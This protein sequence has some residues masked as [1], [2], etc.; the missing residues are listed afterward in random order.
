[1]SDK[2]MQLPDQINEQAAEWFSLMQSADV[3]DKD[4][5]EFNDWLSEHVDHQQAYEQIELVWQTLGDVS[6]T[7]EGAALS[8]S[9]EPFSV[10]LK[11]FLSAPVAAIKSLVAAPKYAMGFAVVCV[12]VGLLLM[13]RPNEPITTYYSTQAGEIK[14]II[15]ADSSE[16]TL[17]A[18]SQISSRISDS[19]RS[20]DLISGEAFFD[21]ASDRQK[22]FFV[23]VNNV[24]VEV[25]GTQFNVQKIRDVVSVAV[26]EGV[27]NVFG[28]TNKDSLSVSLPDAV[29][30]AGQKVVKASGRAF[31]S[32]TAVPPSDLGAWRLGRLIYRDISLADVVTDAGRY[33]EGKIL[34][35][36]EDLADVKVTMTLRTDQVAQLPQ[37]LA[38]TL[39]LEV[40][41][42]SDKIILRKK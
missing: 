30:T 16:I 7:A 40:H 4:R 34:L 28:Q 21:V 25:V 33:F 18:K 12:A 31:E 29:L 32:V 35:Q 24:S 5:Q 36:S 38:Q 19:T 3:S 23:R 17:G 42:V 26:L 22:P 20:V 14:T 15:L 2:V 10:Q 6:G 1:M 39:P 11:S 9:V 37:M 8:R 13:L 41:V 27:V